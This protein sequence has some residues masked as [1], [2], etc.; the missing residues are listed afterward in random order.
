[1]DF[2]YPRLLENHKGELLAIYYWATRER[3]QQH[4]AASRWVP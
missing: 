2:G 3:S 1:M 4:I